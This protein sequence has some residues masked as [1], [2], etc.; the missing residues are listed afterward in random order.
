[1]QTLKP[2]IALDF[3]GVVHQ[4][5]TKYTYPEVI[6]DPPVPG[7]FEFIETMSQHYDIVIFSSRC[8]DSRTRKAMRSWFI[9]HGLDIETTNQLDITRDK[10]A[11]DIYIDD[12]AYCFTGKFPSLEFIR[13]F[14]PWN[15]GDRHG[16][17]QQD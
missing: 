7:A 2:Q 12:R 16:A 14:K 3:D 9:E 8:I 13:A 6:P 15:Y 11:C 17:K 1:M 10:P 4:Y 5:T